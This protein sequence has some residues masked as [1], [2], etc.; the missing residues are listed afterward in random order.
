VKVLVIGSGGREHT[1][2]WKINQS[3]HVKQ[4]FCA[5]GNAGTAQIG[6]NAPISGS[7]IKGLI[8]FVQQEKV[9]LTVVGPEAPLV[10]GVV[11]RFRAEGLK[12]VG[13]TAL[14]AQLEG[15]KAFTKDFLKTNNI[16]TAEFEI[17]SSA[18]EAEKQLRQGRFSFPTVVKADG[19]A[20]GKGVLICR[21]LDEALAAV[22]LVMR[23]RKF[24]ESGNRV[25][26][27]D[28]LQGEEASF[29]VFTDGEVFVPMVPSQDHKAIFEGDKGPNTGGM[30]AYSV[31]F[32][33]SSELRQQIID[34]VIVP[35]IEGMAELGHPIQGILY[36]GLMLTESGPKVLEFNV[37]F[38]D[39]E[40]QAV[41]PRM[42]TPLVETFMAMAE[43]SLRGHQVAWKENAAVCVVVASEGYPGSYRKGCEISGISMAEE[44]PDTVVF[45]AG[46]ELDDGRVLSSGGRVLGVTSLAPTL[47]SSIIQVYEAVNKIHFDGMYYRRDIAS[48]GL[49]KLG[50]N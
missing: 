44:D 8:D 28:F 33:L 22:D 36:A 37:R 3:E 50:I 15:S 18:D 21:D 11:D 45:H 9:D 29:M 32:L 20:A 43:G 7:D 42:D 17:F 47:E 12:V 27:E 35:T 49:R 1:I 23:E 10:A 2:A 26:I 6:S 16:P 24:G 30:G 31:D 4:V 25:V 41:L 14:A 5:H 38:G 19:L 46:T 13:P 34:G 40:T 48:K 39:P